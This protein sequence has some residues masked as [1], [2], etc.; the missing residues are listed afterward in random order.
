MR[1][2]ISMLVITTSLVAGLGLGA[3]KKTEDTADP[4][5]A[6]AS[7]SGE[8]ADHDGKDPDKS[9]VGIDPELAR[10]CDLPETDFAFDS[11]KLGP[12]A[13]SALDALVACFDDGPAK[14]RR[15]TLVGHADP[16]GDEEYN[17]G[18]GQRRATSV[19]GYLSKH[20]LSNDRMETSSRGELDATGTDETGWAHDRRVDI[21][22]AD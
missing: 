22:L 9:T 12:Q 14:G 17:L 15:M 1:T 7:P 5:T 3:C 16:R 13:K 11:A 6:T 20:G 18:L 2:T 8:G 21:G 19:S 4:A 10:M